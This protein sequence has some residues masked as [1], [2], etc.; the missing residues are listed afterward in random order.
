MAKPVTW[1]NV[2]MLT[3][4]LKNLGNQFN[5]RW[6]NRDGASDGAVSDPAHWA[7]SSTGHSPDDTK[8]SNAEYNDNDGKPEIRA[9]DVDNT[10]ND[11]D[12]TMQMVIDHMRKLPNLGSVIRYMIYNKKMYHV[13]NGFVGVAYNGSSPH[14]E[15]AHFSGARSQASDNNTTFD[16]K[17]DELGDGM[18]LTD[19]DVQKIWDVPR[20]KNAYSG[21]MQSPGTILSYVPSRSP[22]DV[23][24][25]KIDALSNIVVAIGAK[26][27]LDPAEIASL[28]EALAVPTAEDN[29]NATVA[30]LL[31]SGVGQLATVL[32]N[33][34]TDEQITELVAQLSE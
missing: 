16:F 29:A 19:A 27:D 30:A 13:N 26:V 4:G 3:P 32:R 10:L 9:I 23:T 31:G 21:A 14:T 2:S 33:A 12:V 17:F 25:A 8:G 34:L 1:N 11:P 6:P 15:H 20:L 24:Q 28:K 18:P 7:E 22:H 5:K